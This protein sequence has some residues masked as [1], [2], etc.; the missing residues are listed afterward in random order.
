MMESRCDWGTLLSLCSYKSTL[1]QTL[2][3][4]CPL[5]SVGATSNPGRIGLGER[6]NL[7]RLL[8]QHLQRRR[9]AAACGGTHWRYALALAVKY[10]GAFLPASVSAAT[11]VLES[12]IQEA[13]GAMRPSG[14]FMPT[15]D[16]TSISWG[17]LVSYQAHTIDWLQLALQSRQRSTESRD[18]ETAVGWLIDAFLS[19]SRLDAREH[20]HVSH[21]LRG[22][23]GDEH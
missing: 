20:C 5:C 22:V 1:L 13:F 16:A 2:T 17:E 4:H 6:F 14:Q 19:T 11:E 10:D 21:A 9:L 8:M 18:L 7:D 3:L 15:P 12:E 23:L